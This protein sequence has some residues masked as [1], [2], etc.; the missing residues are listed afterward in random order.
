MKLD[1]DFYERYNNEVKYMKKA[2]IMT[3]EKYQDHEVIYPYYRVQESGYEVD[4]MSNKVGM[5]YG[6]L[7]T[8]NECTKS[9]FDLNEE[10]K[11]NQYLEEYD[12]LII[13][14]GVKSLEKLRQEQSAL[15]FV[16]EWDSRGKTIGSICHGGQMLISSKIVKGRDVSGYYSI[17]DDLIN[18]GGNFVD[19]ESVVDGNLICCPHYKWMGQWMNKVIEINNAI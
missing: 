11:F 18:A 6:I 10:E 7:G 17:K 15:D 19:A 5:I 3:W 1:K 12:L 2:L 8:Y 14:G 4:I 9:V 13:P 16:K